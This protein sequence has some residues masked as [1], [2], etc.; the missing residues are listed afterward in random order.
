MKILILFALLA[1]L[2]NV[3]A[4][5]QA[6]LQDGKSVPNSESRK[7]I[8]GFGACLI[9]TSDADWE[10]KWNTP[11]SEIPKI[12]TVE[13]LKREDKAWILIMFANPL[14]DVAGSV[15]V[16]CDIR[17]SRPNGKVTEDKGLK[18]MKAPLKGSATN[19]FLAD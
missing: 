4:D 6:W 11:A 17:I 3:R 16:T 1:Q 19:T 12:T 9:I 2:T 8:N 15:N 10:N 14:P 13:N 7:S 5:S 18:A